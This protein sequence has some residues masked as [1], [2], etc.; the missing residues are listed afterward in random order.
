MSEARIEAPMT[1]YDDLWERARLRYEAVTCQLRR[2]TAAAWVHWEDL[3]PEG[4][5]Q[6]VEAVAYTER[7]S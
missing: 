4:Q 7:A 1:E 6:W 3:D 5:I 2:V